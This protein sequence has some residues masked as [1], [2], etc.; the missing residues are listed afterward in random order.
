MEFP[1]RSADLHGK[2][3]K[4]E[5]LKNKAETHQ[6]Q[7]YTCILLSTC[8]YSSAPHPNN[9]TQVALYTLPTD[10]TSLGCLKGVKR[11]RAC[12]KA[13]T[14]C[15]TSLLVPGHAFTHSS[16]GITIPWHVC[17]Q[18]HSAQVVRLSCCSQRC[19]EEE[20]CGSAA[21]NY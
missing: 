21:Q 7:S 9:D 1:T 19:W 18:L 2:A 5:H 11:H 12:F 6:R 8:P 10:Q 14:G 13:S 17:G 15:I 20:V 16:V 4:I 3:I